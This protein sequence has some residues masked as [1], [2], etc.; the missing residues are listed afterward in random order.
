VTALAGFWRYEGR[1]DQQLRCE[2]MLKAQQVYAPASISLRCTGAAALGRRLFSLLPEDRFDH[3]PVASSGDKRLLVADVRLD[4]REELASAA[5]IAPADLRLMSDAALLMGALDKW[6]EEAVD[7]LVGDFAFALWDADRQRLTMARDFMGQRPLHYHRGRDFFALASMPKGLHALPEIPV[8]PDR[9]ATADFL[10]LMPETGTETFF[11]GIEKVRPGHVVLVTRNGVSSRRYWDPQPR[12]LRLPKPED[13]AEALREHL[14][15]AVATR[16]RGADGHVAAHL[17]GGLDSSAVAATAARLLA[18]SGRVSAFTAVPRPGYVAEGV[19]EAIPDEGPLAALVAQLHPNMEHFTISTEGKSQLDALDRS[20]YLYERPV[21]N[22]CNGVWHDAILDAARERRLSVILTG[23]AGNMSFSYSGMY[24]LPQLLAKGYL[25]TLAREAWLLRRNGMRLRTIGSQALGPFL[26]N[27]IWQGINRLRKRGRGLSE[28]SM[29]S[30]ARASKLKIEERAAERGLDVAYRPRMNAFATRLWVL[31]RVDTGNYNKG[32]L[33]G[34]GIDMRDPTADRNL[35][36][37]CLSVPPEQYL[38][39]GVN[40][41]LARN[42]FADRLPQQVL[43]ERL[44]GYQA[45]DWHE[46]LASAQEQVRQELKALQRCPAASEALD[47]RAME[48][49]VD[50]LPANGWHQQRTTRQ[51]RLALLRG[52]SGGNFLR[53]ASGSN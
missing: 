52:I 31:G 20:F 10:A 1:S 21:L 32:M 27:A 49:L 24:L 17:S 12:L 43:N 19:G 46:G 4:N 26:P 48:E 5:G 25:L 39:H 35:V 3:G 33:G 6:D 9:R 42:A 14:D 40:R 50:N 41:A 47:I 37:F 29:L 15:R 13:Y 38:S 7:R 45:A 22:L 34:W 28:Y 2:R 44:K 8:A 18:P 11:E 36:E 16:L 53:K 23:A 51:Y 30:K